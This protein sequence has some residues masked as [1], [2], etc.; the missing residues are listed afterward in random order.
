[1]ARGRIELEHQRDFTGGLNLKDNPYNLAPNETYD[2]QN[3]DIDERG[4]F[5]IRRGHTLFISVP[6]NRI[7]TATGASRTANV[8]TATGLSPLNGDPG[9]LK[10]GQQITVD[11]ADNT[12]D[13]TF[14]VTVA[15]GGASTAQWAQ[16]AADDASAGAGTISQGFLQ[17]DSGYTYV[18]PSNARHTLAARG[19]NVQRFDG[20]AWQDVVQNGGASGTTIF[21]EMNNNLYI[22]RPN[23]VVPHVWTGSGMATS[24]TTAVGNY[25]DDLTAPNQG[26][27]PPCRTM[28]VHHEVMWAANVVDTGPVDK[29]CRVRW[30]HIAQ[31]E[32][33]RTN[34]FIDIDADDENGQIRALVP[35]GDRLLVFKDKAV[36][37]I[38]GY[39]PSGFTVQNL[40]KELGAST[41]YAVVASEDA[42]YFWDVDKGLWKYDGKSFEWVFEP[43]YP[44]IEDNKLNMPF[45]FQVIVNFFRDRVW[46]S[47]PFLSAPYQNR[48]VALIFAPSVGKRGAWTLHDRTQLGWWVHRGSV[49]GDLHLIGGSDIALL[50][51]TRGFITELDTEGV[52]LDVSSDPAGSVPDTLPISAHYATRWFDGKNPAQRKRWKRPVFVVMGGVAQRTVIDVLDDYNPAVVRKTFDLITTLDGTEGQWDVDDWDD[53]LWAAETVFGADRSTIVRGAP[54][55]GGVA[56]ALRMRNITEGQD[57][58]ILGLTMK[59]IPKAIRN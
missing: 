21:A 45:S 27:F 33:W 47:A 14:I 20:A 43:L 11:F 6:T 52:F 55:G 10:V 23:R 34:D 48:F 32:D 31:P 56:K 51:G 30:S 54:L 2:L 41:H 16:T 17:A 49:G 42:V 38:H 4:G 36:Y 26:N 8:V 25:N 12:Y 37:A 3:V 5:G 1:M 44:L 57:W 39:P 35:F 24:L 18:D 15:A 59:W 29:T 7:V 58:R 28:C 50:G 22:L 13:G 19:G 53:A 9:G 40:T 46:C